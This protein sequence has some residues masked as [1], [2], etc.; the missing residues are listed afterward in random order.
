[1]N[2]KFLKNFALVLA[3]GFIS[4]TVSG[5][6]KK[7]K[8]NNESNVSESTNTQSSIKKIEFLAMINDA[9]NITTDGSDEG[10]IKGAKDWDIINSDAV[11]NPDEKIDKEFVISSVMRATGFVDS[12]SS[13]DEIIDCAIEYGVITDRDLSKVDLNDAIGYI[14]KANEA[15]MNPN[16]KNEIKVELVEGVI[17]L[18]N[19]MSSKDYSIDGNNITMDSKYAANIKADTVFILPKDS[20]TGKG[21][22]YKAKS[23]STVNGKTTIL[24]TPASVEEVYKSISSR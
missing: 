12:K 20:V 3:I 18:T 24:G 9:F 16:F 8:D 11:I 13:M 19:A 17:D 5:C 10:T 6:D 23:V 1:M 7:E 15:W 4:F 2:K 14:A 21:G 22:A